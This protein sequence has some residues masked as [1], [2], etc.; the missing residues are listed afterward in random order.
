MKRFTILSMLLAASVATTAQAED[1]A[2]KP[3]AENQQ[4]NLPPTK[5]PRIDVEDHLAWP[6]EVGDG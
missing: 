6:K 2:Q 3:R 5:E 1:T 4:L